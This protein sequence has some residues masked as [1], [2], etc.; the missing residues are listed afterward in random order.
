MR[1]GEPI[2][3]RA[4]GCNGLLLI[5][6][7]VPVRSQNAIVGAISTFRDKTEMSQ[8]VQR[9]DGMMSYVDAPA[10]HFARVYEQAARDPRPAEYEKL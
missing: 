2:Y 3:D 8:L 1:S 5:S 7:T 10:H 9:L 4:L 6:N